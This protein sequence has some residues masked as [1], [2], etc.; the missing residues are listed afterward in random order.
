MFTK[1]CQESFENQASLVNV[2]GDLTRPG[3]PFEVG[4]R[5]PISII[6]NQII[7]LQVN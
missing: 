5:H 7:V 6:K 1:K 2:F 4:S 3:E